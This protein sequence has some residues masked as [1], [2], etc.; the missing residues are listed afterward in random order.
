LAGGLA[1]LVVLLAACFGEPKDFTFT[2]QP[3]LDREHVSFSR[4]TTLDTL[5]DGS[6][7]RSTVQEA[8]YRVKVTRADNWKYRAVMTPISF[9]VRRDGFPVED[10]MVRALRE[11]S[12]EM[13]VWDDGSFAAVHGFEEIV[14]Q[15]RQHVPEEAWASVAAVF[16][17]K[18][19]AALTKAEW[20]SQVTS[21][22]NQTFTMGDT[23]E[24]SGPIDHPWGFRVD[25]GS[26][27]HFEAWQ[28]CEASV[29]KDCV[30]MKFEYQMD[31]EGA[32]A[33]L[34]RT[35]AA[36]IPNC[37]QGLADFRVDQLTFEG[38]GERLVEPATLDVY[39]ETEQ[40][41]TRLELRDGS[42]SAHAFKRE[43]ERESRIE[44]PPG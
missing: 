10:P 38:R 13:E 37:P 17:E 8:R 18:H 6:A 15:L 36:M 29:S 4:R 34:G 19:L 44:P 21:L 7:A 31:G 32:R 1:L 3:E 23:W 35:L 2:F 26:M 42:G 22:V 39:K 9:S 28:A 16:N 14:G 43:E 40:R 24:Y 27:V 41:L 25:T 30:L 20:E 5:A 11:T 12:L 33:W